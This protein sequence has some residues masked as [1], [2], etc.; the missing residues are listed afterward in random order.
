MSEG[1]ALT[2]DPGTQAGWKE[3]G[4]VSLPSTFP[5]QVLVLVHRQAGGEHGGAG[6]EALGGHSDIIA[7]TAL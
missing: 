7:L 4:Q 2:A 6:S 5:L 1:R 3:R